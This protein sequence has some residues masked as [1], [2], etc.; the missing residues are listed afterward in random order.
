MKKGSKEKLLKSTAGMA[1]TVVRDL[2]IMED[3]YTWSLENVKGSEDHIVNRRV[4]AGMNDAKW[5]KMATYF[6]ELQDSTSDT[7]LRGLAK[8]LAES[9]PSD[10]FGMKQTAMYMIEAARAPMRY[11]TLLFEMIVVHAVAVLE[12]FV[13]NYLSIVYTAHPSMLKSSRE[14]KFE[15]LAAVKSKKH[16]LELMTARELRFASNLS[17]KKLSKYLQDKFRF[18]L[19]TEFWGFRALSEFIKIRN[20]I[21]HQREPGLSDVPLSTGLDSLAV[22][23]ED[24][25]Q[26][27]HANVKVIQAFVDYLHSRISEK[28]KLV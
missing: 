24:G 27:V 4:L 21:V 10:A 6:G 11:E 19:A 1:I 22:K 18:D 12:S 17:L 28:L 14:M 9:A 25:I 3:F 13:K 20:Y 7:S 16:L 26:I 8:A 15:E 2:N 23:K 5:A